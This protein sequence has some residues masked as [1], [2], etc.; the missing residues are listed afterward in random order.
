[1]SPADL[2]REANLDE[3][4]ISRLRN[5]SQV[6]TIPTLIAIKNATKVPL[7]TILEEMGF[8]D[9]SSPDEKADRQIYEL[10][11]KMPIEEKVKEIR[12]IELNMEL[13]NEAKSQK[14]TGAKPNQSSA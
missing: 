1:M 4:L 7:L 6:P 11:R 12:R 13:D 10:L 5:T 8:V 3:G 9:S 2:A 14:R